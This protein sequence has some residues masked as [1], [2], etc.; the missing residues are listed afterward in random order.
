[1]RFSP[2]YKDLSW[3]SAALCGLAGVGAVTA[4]ECVFCILY[5]AWL[6]ET[7]A[8]GYQLIYATPVIFSLLAVPVVILIMAHPHRVQMLLATATLTTFTVVHF[9][10][11]HKWPGFYDLPEFSRTPYMIAWIVA[12]VAG[13]LLYPSLR[14]LSGKLAV[15]PLVYGGVALF[16]SWLDYARGLSIVTEI[17]YTRHV[18]ITA[19]ASLALLSVFIDHRLGNEREVAH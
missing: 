16:W 4:A 5:D 9:R 10:G 13:I 12:I 7:A 14:A 2:V 8:P 15:L 19:I 1:M 17:P 6:V 3:S 11:S 18:A